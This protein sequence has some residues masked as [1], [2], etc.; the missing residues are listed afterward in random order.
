MHILLLF[1]SITIELNQHVQAFSNST[2][3]RN[4]AVR[5]MRNR[6]RKL[7]PSSSA[8]PKRNLAN[9]RNR[10]KP[11]SLFTKRKTLPPLESLNDNEGE[12]IK[13]I[14]GPFPLVYTNDPATVTQWIDKYV[15]RKS[16]NYVGFDTESVPDAP[17]MVERG[18][19]PGPATVQLSTMESSLVVHLSHCR[20]NLVPP[21]LVELLYSRDVVKVG[22]GI[23]D[24]ML[25][26]YRRLNFVGRCR[27]DLAGIHIASSKQMT[28]LKRL[29]LNI[30]GV[31]MSK[32]KKLA[33]SDWSLLPLSNKQLAYC[34]RDA[35]AGAALMD[36]LMQRRPDI[37][38]IDEVMSLVNSQERDLEDIDQRARSRK[39]A[40][41][42]LKKLLYECKLRGM[43]FKGRTEVDD[44]EA[45]RRIDY[46]QDSLGVLKPDGMF[47]FDPVQ[48]E[49]FDESY[50]KTLSAEQRIS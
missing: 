19:V 5:K 24:D 40:K 16:I 42:A 7:N 38:A 20:N 13:S 33:R 30:L 3:D 47:I 36:V 35:W 23:D 39:K 9:P 37:F 11:V 32:S 8:T 21:A 12:N 29:V 48:L 15:T 18:K 4:S 50:E 22:V 17:W 10:R 41:I 43:E 25:E 31:K 6:R 27:F 46:L 28:G 34:A 26:L 44:K 45:Q 1:L 49:L 14:A 2:P